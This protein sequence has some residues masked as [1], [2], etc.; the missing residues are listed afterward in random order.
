MLGQDYF[1]WLCQ[2]VAP[3]GYTNLMA[4][5]ASTDYIWQF[6]LDENRAWA[7]LNLRIEFAE[8]AGI[9]QSD[10][11]EGPCSCLEMMIALAGNMVD[12][13]GCEDERTFFQDFLSNMG[14]IKYDDNHWN[15]KQVN[16]ILKRW[17]D[18]RYDPDGKGNLLIT[19]QNI[20]MRN[21]DTW[22][23]MAVYINE[24]YP[25]DMDFLNH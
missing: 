7:G 19:R 18:R 13:S 2:R 9:Y 24:F 15:E 12:Q 6:S 14:L 5:L 20:D 17:L 8:E 3:I 16:Y 1:N 4:K 22:Q 21:L 10:V 23:Q 25:L 11:A